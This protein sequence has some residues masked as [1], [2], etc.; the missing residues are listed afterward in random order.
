M[1]TTG[2]HGSGWASPV[3]AGKEVPRLT[4]PPGKET[5]QGRQAQD[6]QG[7]VRSAVGGGARP[8]GTSGCPTARRSQSGNPVTSGAV[9]EQQ[10]RSHYGKDTRSASLH[11][12]G[13][14]P[15]PRP[16]VKHR[17]PDTPSSRLP[18][19]LGLSPTQPRV[20]SSRQPA[21]RACPVCTPHCHTP[22][23]GGEPGTL[24]VTAI[25]QR[26]PQHESAAGP[27]S[28]PAWR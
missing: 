27:V 21:P 12:R 26:G 2:R 6:P 9:W 8:P 3:H 19:M 1:K 23:C 20:H 16:P 24:D 4:S 14:A 15:S 5:Q 22:E 10:L 18:G 17:T 28:L 25:K 7:R 13:T 11:P